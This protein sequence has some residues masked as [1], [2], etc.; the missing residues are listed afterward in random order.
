MIQNGV[1]MELKFR[2]LK[3]STKIMKIKTPRNF[4]RIWYYSLWMP[5]YYSSGLQI[6]SHEYANKANNDDVPKPA[7][8][9]RTGVL[10]LS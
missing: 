9:L 10:M 1:K 4:Q 7:Q 2:G 3:V 5:F 8:S 6:Q